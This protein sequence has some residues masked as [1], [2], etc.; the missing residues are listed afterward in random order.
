MNFSFTTATRIGLN[1]VAGLGVAVALW[2]GKSIFIPF[3]IA[4][5]LAM[6][7]YPASKWLHD[8][9]KF[10]WFAATSTMILLLIIVNLGAFIG[11]GSTVPRV[12]Q[13][14]PNP[15]NQE[16]IKVFYSQ[17]RN[18][19]QTVWPGSID[20][21]FPPEA[22]DSR[23][24]AY[25]QKL[26]EGDLL[27]NFLVSIGRY[28][29][30]FLWQSVLTLF[31][32]LFLLME[33][34]MLGRRIRE[35][36]GSSQITQSHVTSAIAEIAASVRAYLLWRTLVNVFLG[37]FLGVVYQACNLRQPWTWALFTAILCYIPY[38]GT[39]IA[40]IPPVID[41]FIYVS[42]L[43]A[44]FILILYIIVVTVEGYYIVPV[45]MGRNMDLNA[46]TVLLTC[47]F[48]DL[49]WGTPGLFLA[50]PLM[51]GV[52]SIC[53]HV[54]GWEP[55]GNLMGTG[56]HRPERVTKINPAPLTGDSSIHSDDP[57]ARRE[58]SE[59]TVVIDS[60]AADNGQPKSN[61][62]SKQNIQ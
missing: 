53:M 9:L 61:D 17:I 36:F 39:I 11:L 5:L 62:P 20:D 18:Q 29:I 34:E 58:D 13:D 56:D 19:I 15:K 22:K 4:G 33:G 51:A 55:W 21:A 60:L 35:I 2:L 43:M 3:T 7:L 25:V 14:L 28:G 59:T 26:F 44:L 41:A 6:I 42:P 12:I 38:I 23:I 8:K 37:V 49:I 46:T 32:L 57:Y 30:E 45:V 47:L 40:G 16:E 52:K 31:I 1:V 48:W 10:P 24:F 50:M 54:P 27:V